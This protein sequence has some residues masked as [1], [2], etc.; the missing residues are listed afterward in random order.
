MPHPTAN[1]LPGLLAVLAPLAPA[2]AAGCTLTTGARALLLEPT[3]SG[4]GPLAVAAGLT[5]AAIVFL[6]ARPRLRRRF[7]RRSP[8]AGLALALPAGVMVTWV[9]VIAASDAGETPA[10]LVVTT[11]CA[12]DHLRHDY[13]S[14]GPGYLTGA[15]V[16]LVLPAGR[17]VVIQ[18]LQHHHEASWI[19]TVLGLPR[20]SLPWVDMRLRLRTAEPGTYSGSCPDLCGRDGPGAVVVEVREEADFQGWVERQRQTASEALRERSRGDLMKLGSRVYGRRCAACH[21]TEGQGV[22]GVFPGLRRNPVVLG[23]LAPHLEVLLD[24]RP[25][26]PMK[27]F[28]QE[29]SPLEAAAVTTYQRNAWGHDTRDL[30]QARLVDALGGPP[31]DH[32]E[33]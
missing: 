20:P 15:H 31:R 11:I 24:G 10:S 23:P 28:R 19:A 1:R 29:L 25:G 9:S 27:A 8:M 13:G 3:P 12:G 17:D 26:T 33:Q 2:S 22:R 30:V 32:G 4:L 7:G 21:G 5:A 14:P 16:P 6:L 18:R